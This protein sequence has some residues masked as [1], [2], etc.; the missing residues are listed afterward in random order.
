MDGL[1]K[2]I[3]V[4]VVITLQL[5][6]L[7]YGSSD[8]TMAEP[9]ETLI[10]SRKDTGFLKVEC[11]SVGLDIYVDNMLVGQS[12]IDV[13]VALPIGDHIV[14]Y[15]HPQFLELLTQY[16]HEQEIQQ[17]VSRSMQTVYI[18]PGQIVSVNLWW[19]PYESH[20]KVRK[21]WIWLKSFVGAVIAGTILALNI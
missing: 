7:L 1:M 14:T 9:E 8:T 2:R 10:I 15:L 4:T 5:T 13:P 16:Y 3:H 18:A 12:P 17:I 11:D 6:A 20:L 19:R 21:R